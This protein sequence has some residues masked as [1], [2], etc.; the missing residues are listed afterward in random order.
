MADGQAAPSQSQLP[1]DLTVTPPSQ[2]AQPVQSP[3][4]TPPNQSSPAPQPT[5]PDGGPLGHAVLGALNNA[6]AT[7]N[8]SPPSLAKLPDDLTITPPQ[9]P[10]PVSDNILDHIPGVASGHPDSIDRAIAGT[11]LEAINNRIE[12]G[13]AKAFGLHAP[14]T[15]HPETMKLSEMAAQTFENIKNA[16]I[17][18]YERWGGSIEEPTGTP[19]QQAVGQAKSVGALAMTVPDMLA[20]GIEGLA[21]QLEHGGKQFVAAAKAGDHGGMQEA[22][23]TL[24]GSLGQLAAGAEAPEA[25]ENAG[26]LAVKGTEYS[27]RNIRG[28]ETDMSQVPGNSRPANVLQ[29]SI[30]RS[31]GATAK[32]VAFGDPSKALVDENISWPGNRGRLVQVNAKL[33]QVGNALDAKLQAAPGSVDVLNELDPVFTKYREEIRLSNATPQLKAQMSHD[34]DALI[35]TA[36]EHAPSGQAS[37]AE[38]N[39]IKQAIGD[40]VNWTKRPAG[41]ELSDTILSAYKEAYAALKNK[42]NDAIGPDGAA[43]NQRFSN[44]KSAQNALR[45]EVKTARAGQGPMSRM[46]VTQRAEAAVGHAATPVITGAQKATEAAKTAAPAIG[47]AAQA[48]VLSQS[49]AKPGDGTNPFRQG[50]PSQP[51]PQQ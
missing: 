26:D 31:V 3:Q 12:Q 28:S 11:P 14:D 50:L 45:E 37:I 9:P 24:L 30:N 51:Q 38:L 2:A 1:N 5:A 49:N 18:S 17:K 35:D 23:G 21:T 7:H 41:M 48:A 27:P 46:G 39:E 10:P 42:V 15:A 22:F 19:V 6:E 36:A 34:L 8:A 4:S 40:S 47:A 33:N 20:S 29:G 13:V 43:L 25:A 44:L 32:D 16:A